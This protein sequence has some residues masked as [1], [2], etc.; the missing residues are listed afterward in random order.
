MSITIGRLEV[1]L[2]E[3]KGYLFY[4]NEVLE[5]LVRHGIDIIKSVD[6][7][8]TITVNS[9]DTEGILVDEYFITILKGL[10]KLDAVNNDT[11]KSR[12]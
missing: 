9:L 2:L 7:D 1:S 5:L 3:F 11:G 6:L 12:E 10:L 4:T 8:F